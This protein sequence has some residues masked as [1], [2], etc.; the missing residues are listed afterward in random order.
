MTYLFFDTE[1]T[2]K[3]ETGRLVQLAF[4]LSCE[5]TIFNE[6]F[7]PPTPISYEAMSVHHITN[8]QVADKKTFAESGY[9][10]TLQADFNKF[11]PVA[12]NAKF[13]VDI[14]QREGMELKRW[15]CTLKVAQTL[16]VMPMYKLQY[17]RYR[18]SL[19]VDD[20]ATAH[21]AEGDVMVLEQLF[22]YLLDEAKKQFECD[23]DEAIEKMLKITADPLLIRAMP[24]GK[25]YGQSFE[26]IVGCDRQY[27]E[28]LRG[29]PDIEP[30]LYFTI[31]HW[32]K[33]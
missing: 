29:K 13:D 26:H 9:K 1:T 33:K 4:K 23:E 27:L 18:L 10:E 25:Y 30:D 8:E 24:F 15:I 16:L 6:L 17:L 7:K 2:H 22:Y 5:K 12:H 28:W 14:L 31:N 20:G 21:D 19:P 32:L 3:D 11:L